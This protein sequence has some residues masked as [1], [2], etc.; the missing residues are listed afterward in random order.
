[1]ESDIAQIKLL[2]WAIL[3]LQILFVV[4]NIACRVLGCGKGAQPDYNELVARGKYDQILS[5]TKKRL[6]TH[7]HDTDA[8]YFRAK[9]L[10]A[11]GLTDSAKEFVKRLGESDQRL[12]LVC[13][14]WLQALDSG[15]QST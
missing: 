7:P 8:L 13:R 12:A 3:G 5:Y 14:E 11:M 9:A 1:M 4:A 6:D 10:Q 2:L 15:P